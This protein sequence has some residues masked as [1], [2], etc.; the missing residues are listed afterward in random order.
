MGW[1]T[2]IAVGWYRCAEE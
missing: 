2:D 1:E